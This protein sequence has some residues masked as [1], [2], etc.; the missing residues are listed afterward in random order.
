VMT[1]LASANPMKMPLKIDAVRKKRMV[2][3]TA[4]GY[5]NAHSCNQNGLPVLWFLKLRCG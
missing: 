1:A 3:M 4:P 5:S 2:R